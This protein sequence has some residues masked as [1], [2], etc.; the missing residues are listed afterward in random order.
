[1]KGHSQIIFVV[2]RYTDC[3]RGARRR[4]RRRSKSKSKSSKRRAIFERSARS[5][6]GLLRIGVRWGDI[7]RRYDIIR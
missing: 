5:A 2:A 3:G 6:K 4:R 1:M 7:W